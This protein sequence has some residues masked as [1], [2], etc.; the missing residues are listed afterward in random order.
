MLLQLTYL[1]GAD[2]GERASYLAGMR[3]SRWLVAAGAGLALVVTAAAL[4]GSG[5]RRSHPNVLIV[6]WDTVRADRMSLYGYS[7]PTTP[8][9]DQF[10]EQAAVYE[11]ATAPG[12][13]TLNTHA[14]M[15]TGLYETTHGARP[16]WRWLDQH[17]TTLAELARG[18]GYDTFLFSSNLIASPMTNLTQGFDTIHT[19][20]PRD[21]AQKGRYMK[22]ARQATRQKLLEQDASTELSPLFAG[23][24]DDEWE[25]SVFKDAAPVAHQALIDWLGERQDS[26]RPFFAYLNLME[27]HSPRIPSLSARRRVADEATL[28]TAMATDFSL[29]AA[30][31][32]II[33]RREYSPEQL[34]AI[35]ATY[36]ASIVDLDD[37]TGDLLDDLRGRGLLEDTVVVVVADHG[38]HLG[39][40]RFFEHRWSMYEPLLHVPLVIWYPEKMPAG[41]VSERVNTI[42]L[43]ATL[44]E[45]AGLEEVGPTFST[46]LVDRRRFD[47]F[48]FS[49]MLDPFASQLQSVQDAYPDD[50]L[51]RWARTYCAVY[52]GDHKL[53]VSS[54]GQHELYDLAQDPGELTER[55]AQDAARR[56]SLLQALDAFEEKLPAY[57][58]GL[59]TPEDTPKRARSEEKAMLELLGYVVGEAQAPL[60]DFCGRRSGTEKP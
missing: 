7:R 39:E 38:E 56:A 45:L 36:D 8:R 16:A 5:Q 53:V 55:S 35:G 10:A 31:E 46:S 29:F 3:A 47:P 51:S 34:G 6:L 42:D 12:M 48:V 25:K 13:W 57:D 37:A 60:R 30:N 52:E 9:L 43:Y 1:R 28:Q 44:V 14:A 59:R 11:R 33:G 21:G 4:W 50:D 17:H 54:D 20:F 18:A 40:H 32:Y 2:E 23:R 22:A 49:Q 24:R 19:A 58:P 26:S 15:F 41:R 27:A